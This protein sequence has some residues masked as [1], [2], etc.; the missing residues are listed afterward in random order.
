[1]KMGL[2]KGKGQW[3]KVTMGTSVEASTAPSQ[4]I[5]MKNIPKDRKLFILYN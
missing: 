1:M 3:G 5:S 2:G 4:P